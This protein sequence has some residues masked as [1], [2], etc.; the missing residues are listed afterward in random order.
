MGHDL[1]APFEDGKPNWAALYR[2][3]S[4]DVSEFRPVL[5][6]DVFDN[7]SLEGPTGNPRARSVLVLQHPCSMRVDGVQLANKLLVAELTNRRPL[8]EAEWLGNFSLMPLPDL[9]P[10]VTSAK[11]D[12]AASFDKLHT[13]KAAELVE[14]VVS[15]SPFGI[16]ILL[17]RWVH[18][19]SRVVVPTWQLQETT[20]GEFEEADLIEDW[21]IERSH[22]DLE[23]ATRE[24][25]DWLRDPTKSPTRQ[26]SLREPQQRAKVRADMRAEIRRLRGTA[27]KK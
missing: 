15:L 7:V 27:T 17:Q 9:R 3:R 24:C 22:L 13:I 2:A 16:N 21:C 23:T 6:G 18:F 4:A 12:Q 14:R 20:E 5:T 1:E 8:A 10:E 26:Q 11:R 25:V 19:S